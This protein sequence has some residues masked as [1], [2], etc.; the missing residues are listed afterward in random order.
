MYIHNMNQTIPVTLARRDLLRLV[1]W[2][3]EKY[4]RVDLVKRGK[5]KASIV[6]PDYLDSL[7]ETVY[8]LSHSLKDIR[9]A[10]K[11]LAKGEYL[12]LSQFKQQ[13]KLRHAR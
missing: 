2:V 13:L 9:E 6:S 5:I 8:T 4:T 11:Q 7:E 12:T 3:D 10:E 1:D